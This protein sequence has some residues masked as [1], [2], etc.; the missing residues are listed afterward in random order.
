M[1][2]SCPHIHDQVTHGKERL[3]SKRL[4]EEVGEVVHRANE[5]HHNRMIFDFFADEEVA[6]FAIVFD[7]N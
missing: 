3:L 4:G 1:S 5:G 2:T 6:Y 7:A